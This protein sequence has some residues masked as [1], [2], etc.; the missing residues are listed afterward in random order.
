MYTLLH[1]VADFK[2]YIELMWFKHPHHSPITDLLHTYQNTHTCI[3]MLHIT[4]EY[5]YFVY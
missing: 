2:Q 4:E 3:I 1:G 5:K